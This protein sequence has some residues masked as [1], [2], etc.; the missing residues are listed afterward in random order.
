MIQNCDLLLNKN[1]LKDK[2]FISLADKY[3]KNTATEEERQYVEAFYAAMQQK[4][5]FIPMNLSVPKKDKIKKVIDATILKKTIRFTYK[6]LSIAASFILIIGIAYSVLNL[7]KTNVT[8]LKGERKEVVLADGSRVFLNA[9]SSISY[10]DDFTEKRNITLIGEAFFQVAKNTE[11]PFTVK[12]NNTETRVLGTS[13]NINSNN[14][15]K[16]IVSVNT[17]KVLVQSRINPRNNVVL[18]KNQQI[19]FLH[20]TPLKISYGN[21]DDLMAW[22]KNI[23]VLNNE[24][25]KNTIKILENWY[26]VS[27]DLKDEDIKNETITGKFNNETLQNVMKSLGL[28]K[29]LKIDYLTPNHIIIRKKTN[30][31]KK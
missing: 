25:L 9:N 6:N 28:L 4:N 14:G 19:S 10:T 22:T 18:T 1:I 8:T 12:A 26:N 23:I 7:N 21:S 29:S 5:K 15:N 13:F 20:D 17:G 3:A 2:H 16:T 31:V 11:K 30:E 27:I 24:T